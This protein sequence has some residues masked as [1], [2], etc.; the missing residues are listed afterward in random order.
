MSDALTTQRKT[1]THFD[2]ALVT[3]RSEKSFLDVTQAI[4]SRLQRFSISKLMEYAI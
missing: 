3:I 1:L 4:E 2:G